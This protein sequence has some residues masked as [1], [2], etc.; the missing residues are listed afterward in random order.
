[1]KKPRPTNLLCI[2]F[3]IS[4]IAR[5]ACAGTITV[6]GDQIITGNQTVTSNQIVRG[7][8]TVSNEASA[9]G[10]DVVGPAHIAGSR[11]RSFG[12]TETNRWIRVAQLG[13]GATTN[14]LFSGR[15]LAEGNGADYVADFAFPA[16][17]PSG[18][19][20]AL[21]VEMGTASN[22][23]W[24][25][26]ADGGAINL[27]FFQPA[28]SRFATF[29]YSQHGCAEGWTNAGAPA[30]THLW[31]STSGERGGIR[32]GAVTLSGAGLRLPDGTLLDARSNMT[33]SALSD[34]S[35][36]L[37]S[38]SGG[39][40]S[41]SAPSMF[42]GGVTLPQ[43]VALGTNGV[44]L[45][46]D[47]WK[48]VDSSFTNGATWS[49]ALV[50]NI[51][52]TIRGMASDTNGNQYVFG[53]FAGTMTVAGS[54]LQ[55]GT[56]STDPDLAGFVVK[57]GAGGSP[58]WAKSFP[59]TNHVANGTPGEWR[60]EIACAKTDAAGNVYLGGTFRAPA[61]IGGATRT[62]SGGG[63]GFVI[64]LAPNGNFR[65]FRQ[66]GGSHGNSDSIVDI[67]VD[68]AGTDIIVGG[69]EW[70]YAA[71]SYWDWESNWVTEYYDDSNG[72]AARL[73]GSGS[74]IS[75][76][77]L[78][79]R[80]EDPN[81]WVSGHETAESQSEFY[82]ST[83]I[84][85]VCRCG[86]GAAVYWTGAG[87]SVRKIGGSTQWDIG[88]GWSGW[89]VR[90]LLAI[91]GGDVLILRDINWDTYEAS[92]VIRVSASGSV[93][94]SRDGAFG[95]D[96][97]NYVDFESKRLLDAVVAADGTTIPS[98]SETW[99]VEEGD[100]LVYVQNMRETVEKVDSGGSVAWTMELPGNIDISR[101]RIDGAGS[102]HAYGTHS[103]T[104]DLG[105][106]G[107]LSGSGSFHLRFSGTSS[108]ALALSVAPQVTGALLGLEASGPTMALACSGPPPRYIHSDS[109]ATSVSLGGTLDASGGLRLADGTVISSAGDLIAMGP[110]RSG[111]TLGSS[112]Y[113]GN[114]GLGTANPAVRLDVSGDT[115]VS[116][117]LSVSSGQVTL[118]TN[119]V[120]L[121]EARWGALDDALQFGGESRA[122]S[123]S[124]YSSIRGMVADASGNRFVYG[125]FAGT[126]DLGGG[127]VLS[128]A[129]TQNDRAGFVLKLDP[130]GYLL[131][132][133]AFP[134]VNH[135]ANGQQNEMLVEIASGKIDGA[136]NLVLAGTFR[137]RAMFAGTDQTPQG[138]GDAFA[139]CLKPDGSRLW[140]QKWSGGG[141]ATDAVSDLAVAP[142]GTNLYVGGTWAKSGG[143]DTDGMVRKIRAADGVTITNWTLAGNPGDTNAT[144][145]ASS[146]T[147]VCVASNDVAV[148]WEAGEA[149][150][151]LRLGTS[152]WWQ[153][154]SNG[155]IGG[156]WGDAQGNVVAREAGG[157][158]RGRIAVLSPAAGD[159]LWS[160]A[161]A[162]SEWVDEITWY[163]GWWQ[164]TVLLDIYA[165]ADGAL[166]VA[167]RSEHCDWWYDTASSSTYYNYSNTTPVQ[168]LNITDGSQFWQSG[169][170][171]SVSACRL[172]MDSVGNLHA[173]GENLHVRF[174]GVGSSIGVSETISPASGSLVDYVSTPQALTLAYQGPP[175]TIV[176]DTDWDVT[177]AVDGYLSVGQ[178]LRLGD[179]T[180][181]SS[182][183][184]IV[185]LGPLQTGT[186]ASTYFLSG[187]FGIGTN[188]PGAKLDV[189]GD[190]RVS[191]SF[192]IGD[193]LVVL[194]SVQGV[195]G[196]FSSLSVD[197]S[198][199]VSGDITAGG[200][201]L[202]GTGSVQLTDASGRLR[203]EALAARPIYVQPAGDI[204]MGAFTNGPAQ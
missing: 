112:W 164:T 14:A 110:W 57:F 27:W 67:D 151:V 147:R 118:G 43:T 177:M 138:A 62:P 108:N 117:G 79:G 101:L 73:N 61:T 187:N 113:P 132:A 72:Y 150:S 120:A 69:T 170:M 181:L 155:A 107:T 189:A 111:S 9:L 139:V 186:V 168:R 58:L 104:M 96:P 198:L 173:V 102:L 12:S 10:L 114:V 191:G 182:A 63:D 71:N 88:T 158:N 77:S 47:R 135:T 53:G 81:S 34:G 13:G 85:H 54:T 89:P 45:T 94:W 83:A 86:D 109:T 201:L 91:P 74:T 99:W 8:L 137:A 136:G 131:W 25:V 37:L 130:L 133:Q 92:A 144:D 52:T 194:G 172:G 184:D 123:A 174:Q 23:A 128:S 26:W 204:P 116:G 87:R 5:P 20:S 106:V 156:I 42:S 193:D 46:A 175:P 6:E 21:L 178:G 33:A 197:G 152:P 41:F 126:M 59:L 140:F 149:R 169:A 145:V 183:G 16:A 17:P 24:E 153:A 127:A 19:Y 196:E 44:T 188:A 199:T 202:A 78:G 171:D 190:A 30:G 56:D 143:S 167:W 148:A 39:Q 93:A 36:I 75:E 124:G 22:I 203:P 60:M 162:Y 76:W 129:T 180:Y 161:G 134:L 65:W 40:L 159:E 179:G 163:Y 7:S 192:N 48:M 98:W 31:S 146:V 115:R 154:R 38:A 97:V 166:F 121:T 49:Q 122:L 195:G 90:D 66:L 35:N 51:G 3:A 160:Q 50:A 11:L 70:G 55:S 103:G 28:G 2:T 84:E 82:W 29:L 141:T 18:P 64:S 119:G 4:V 68:P 32:A 1:M 157:D 142:G 100:P 80:P 185:G 15:V 200:V 105:Q 95:Y 125:A 176:Q 165:R